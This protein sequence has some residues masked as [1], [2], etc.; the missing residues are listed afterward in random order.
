MTYKTHVVSSLVIGIAT[1]ELFGQEIDLYIHNTTYFI[2]Y[3]GALAFGA[4]FPDIDEPKSYI[5]KRFG[6]LSFIF[7]MF[8][9]HRGITHTLLIVI[10]IIIGADIFV[11]QEQPNE[12][13]IAHLHLYIV[14]VDGFIIGYIAHL[15]GDSTT[16]SGIPLF[17]PLGDD[18]FTILPKKLCY[19]TGGKVEKK[20]VLP[21]LTIILIALLYYCERTGI[22]GWNS[23][24]SSFFIDIRY[25]T[26]TISNY[27]YDL[28][29]IIKSGYFTTMFSHVE[30]SRYI[31]PLLSHI[32]ETA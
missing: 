14:L 11:T 4:L 7:R 2:L 9:H 22:L 32:K 31:A 28:T 20:L 13:P 5:G 26:V 23:I 24:K 8:T 17:F 30:H 1:L 10:M 3:L 12:F 27:I 25:L 18:H 6:F 15:L 19:V 29:E 16:K 21:V